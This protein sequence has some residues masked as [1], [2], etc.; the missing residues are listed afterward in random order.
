[1]Y[2]PTAVG[3]YEGDDVGV[4]VGSWGALVGSLLGLRV[5]Y[6]ARNV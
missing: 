1:M 3:V 6:D 5:G 2:H 4:A